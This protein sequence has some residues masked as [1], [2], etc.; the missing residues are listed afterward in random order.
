MSAY[1][2]RARKMLTERNMPPPNKP[3]FDAAT[4]PFFYDV[5]FES[6]PFAIPEKD[7]GKFFS[8]EAVEQLDKLKKE[9]ADLKRAAPPEQPMA[10]AVEEGGPVEQKVSRRCDDN[11]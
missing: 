5:Y 7:E 2:T 1:R 6:G 3:E 8:T 10:C 9:A 4:D 11:S